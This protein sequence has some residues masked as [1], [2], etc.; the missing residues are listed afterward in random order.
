M[1][2]FATTTLWLASLLF[3][4]L[5]FVAGNSFRSTALTTVR[6]VIAVA[7]GWALSLSYAVAANA[8]AVA[9][10]RTEERLQQVYASDGA[11]LATAATL[12]WVLPAIIVAVAWVLHAR[13]LSRHRRQEP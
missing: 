8:V 7:G 13:Y 1:E 10:A 4:Y 9:T 11:P 12:G 3:P 6:A 2:N 5:L